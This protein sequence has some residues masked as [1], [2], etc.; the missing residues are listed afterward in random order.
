M[1]KFMITEQQQ[2]ARAKFYH[3]MAD[4]VWVDA[5]ALIKDYMKH[6]VPDREKSRDGLIAMRLAGKKILK[7][8]AKAKKEGNLV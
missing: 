1:S 7:V 8:L 3:D 6:Q 4:S 5:V 2:L